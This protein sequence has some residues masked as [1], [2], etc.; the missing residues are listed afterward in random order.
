MVM[1]FFYLIG[2]FTLFGDRGGGYLLFVYDGGDGPR[3]P[4]QFRFGPNI[5]FS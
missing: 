4:P 2:S 5:V 1:N 3:A